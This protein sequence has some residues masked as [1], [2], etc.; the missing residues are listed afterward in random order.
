MLG[1]RH[2][3]PGDDEGAGGRDVEGAGGVAAGADDIDRAGRGVDR[4]R[5]PAH[6][7]GRAGDLV[8][9]LAAHPERHQQRADLGR[10]RIAA[11]D[12][13]ER[14]LGLAF[15]QLLAGRHLG[16]ERPQI[17]GRCVAHRSILRLSLARRIAELSGT[18]A[19]V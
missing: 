6:D 13:V 11:H 15:G 7:A 14:R 8:D 19:Q 5:L 3:T 16:Q 10:R 1:D 4:K 18:R 17:A 2:A 12:D 9:G